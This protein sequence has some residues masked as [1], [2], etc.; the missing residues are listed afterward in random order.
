MFVLC[1]VAGVVMPLLTLLD[2]E[3]FFWAPYT[4]LLLFVGVLIYF[5]FTGKASC[6][7]CN[8]KQFAPKNCLKHRDAHK[9]PVIGYMLPTALHAIYYRWFKC[10]F[11]GTSV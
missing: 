10:I 2:K 8:Q 4:I 5:M 3:M 9:L 1:M 7:I 11:C 6:P